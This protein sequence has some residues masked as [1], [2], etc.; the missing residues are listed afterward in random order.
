MSIHLEV[1]AYGLLPVENA[2]KREPHGGDRILALGGRTG[3]DGIHGASLLASAEFDEETD[4]KRPSANMKVAIFCSPLCRINIFPLETNNSL[5]LNQ[6]GV[7]IVLT[8]RIRHYN[9]PKGT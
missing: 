7:R 9:S 2:P 6:I 5:I 8:R 1:G 3:R 4:D